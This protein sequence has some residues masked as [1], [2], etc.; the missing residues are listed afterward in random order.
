V[1]TLR[2]AGLGWAGLHCVA[3]L[4]PALCCAALLFPHRTIHPCVPPL[5]HRRTFSKKRCYLKTRAG[6]NWKKL[7]GAV[8]GAIRRHGGDK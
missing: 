3:L 8:S 2:C 6:K 5:H 4:C 1:S 7:S